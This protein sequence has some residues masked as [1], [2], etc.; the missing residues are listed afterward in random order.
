M[1]WATIRLCALNHMYSM[2]IFRQ[3]SIL[4]D[5]NLYH[6]STP[7]SL[8]QVKEQSQVKSDLL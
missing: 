8:A 3:A 5:K 4:M 7:Q 1:S 6:A 2:Y